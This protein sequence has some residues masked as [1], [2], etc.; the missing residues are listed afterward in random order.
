MPCGSR[1]ATRSTFCLP[2]LI[3]PSEVFAW[4]RAGW[5]TAA[6]VQAPLAL[7]RGKHKDRW[8]LQYSAESFNRGVIGKLR[9][10]GLRLGL[11]TAGAA[12]VLL[13]IGNLNPASGLP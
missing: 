4:L 6:W 11:L 12:V 2:S 8:T 10:A 13:S 7:L 5:F 1:T 3:I 9:V